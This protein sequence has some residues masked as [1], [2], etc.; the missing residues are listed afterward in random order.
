MGRGGGA[1]GALGD[2]TE[3]GALARGVVA[4]GRSGGLVTAVHRLVAARPP[5]ALVTCQYNNTR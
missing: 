5:A 1:G 3:H 2:A 4:D